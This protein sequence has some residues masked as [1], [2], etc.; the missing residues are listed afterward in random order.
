MKIRAAASLVLALAA[1]A[2]LAGCTLVSPQAT[3]LHYDASDGVGVDVGGVKVRN[4][5]LL[6]SPEDPGASSTTANFIF[7]LVNHSGE[8]GTL[9]VSYSA[10]GDSTS[11]EIEFPADEGIIEVGYGTGEQF[12]LE[13]VRLAAGATVEV[14][15]TSSN[16]T[17]VQ[18]FVPVLDGSITPYGSYLPTV[19]PS[20]PSPTDPVETL[21][22]VDTEQPQG[23]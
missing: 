7:G 8:A 10:D 12:V 21:E 6:I 1:A 23:P 19:T 22:P 4:A 3:T 5:I 2:G 13:G 16:G 17:T 20:T 9:T 11:G 18:A 15:F 14:T